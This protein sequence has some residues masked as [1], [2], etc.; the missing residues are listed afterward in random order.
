MVAGPPV[1]A[2]MTK[3]GPQMAS[4]AAKKGKKTVAKARA[5]GKPAG[6][7]KPGKTVTKSAKATK[8]AGKIAAKTAKATKTTK[9][10]TKAAKAA[11]P[12]K[13]AKPTAVPEGYGTVTPFLTID[14][15]SDAIEFYK[16]AF[17][18]TERL[19]MPGPEG[20]LMHAEITIGNSV[21]MLSD[22]MR[23]PA[24][25]SAIHL[26][27]EDCDATFAQALD[28]GA[29][30]TMPLMDMFWGDRYGQLSDP[31]GNL[32]SIATHKEDL[33]QEEMEKR[34]AEAPPPPDSPP[35]AA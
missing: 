5:S 28:A 11:K 25:Q 17:G 27:V 15:A 10:S 20:K 22:A 19:R 24:T 23:R 33:S 13:P 12:S 16:K 14:G 35:A 30:V 9:T 1:P 31:F 32:W 29:T 21:V 34:M 4:K 8:P 7:A 18:A 26:Y 3:G 6:K 2:Q